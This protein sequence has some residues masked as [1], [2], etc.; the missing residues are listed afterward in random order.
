MRH[1]KLYLLV[2][3]AATLHERK[4]IIEQYFSMVRVVIEE[5]IFLV[6]RNVYNRI[7]N[8][9]LSLHELLLLRMLISLLG[10]ERPNNRTWL[11]I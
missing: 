1:P 8:Y 4:E 9:M 2:R 7:F 10:K 11:C 5:K 3:D 6:I